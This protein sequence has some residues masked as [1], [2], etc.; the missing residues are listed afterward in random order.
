MVGASDAQGDRRCV[1]NWQQ[2]S[3]TVKASG[4]VLPPCSKWVFAFFSLHQDAVTECALAARGET[5]HCG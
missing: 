5:E 3:G 1:E 2:V 4:S